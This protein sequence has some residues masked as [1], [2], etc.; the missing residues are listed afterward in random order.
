[1][2]IEVVLGTVEII[3]AVLALGAFCAGYLIGVR[4]RNRLSVGIGVVAAGVIITLALPAGSGSL[5]AK[6]GPI[7][8]EQATLVA[9]A[10]SLALIGGFVAGVIRQ[11]GDRVLTGLVAA[12]VVIVGAALLKSAFAINPEIIRTVNQLGLG[13]TARYEPEKNKDCPENLKSLYIAFSMYTEDYGAL[14][15][16]AN[17]LANDDLVSK[18]RQDEWLHC[19]AV[20]NRHDDKY[21]YAYNDAVAGRNLN[22]KPLKEM[23]DAAHTPLLYDSTDLAKS[24][25]DAFTSLP[26][27]GRHGGR[28][29]VLYCDGT[30]KAIEPK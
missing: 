14:P 5:A 13:H 11:R 12:L 8:T 23:P 7:V 10:W 30:V 1:L 18:V 6:I 27:P 9:R 22:G 20:S 4:A 29:N 26:R 19:P 17:W 21:G 25:H 16:A 28:D 24:A 3:A 2:H 15:P